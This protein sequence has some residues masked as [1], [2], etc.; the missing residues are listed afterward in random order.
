MLDQS[1]FTSNADDSKAKAIASSW[2]KM[3]N[4]NG[5]ISNS[6]GINQECCEQKKISSNT[7]D[8]LTSNETRM[9]LDTEVNG[10]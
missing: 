8:Q 7:G 6:G 5:S 3:R 4:L 10:V 2:T 9:I 1:G